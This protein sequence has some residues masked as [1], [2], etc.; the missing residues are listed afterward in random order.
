MLDIFFDENTYNRSNLSS[1]ASC[2]LYLPSHIPESPHK[3]IPATAGP[4]DF[5]GPSHVS[6]KGDIRKWIGETPPLAVVFCGKKKILT[7]G[8]E[9]RVRTG[10]ERSKQG[11][12][13]LLQRIGKG[14]KAFPYLFLLHACTFILL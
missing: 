8:D 3:T 10:L 5:D 11:N 4:G 1:P 2:F 6:P 13:F 12:I 7:A 14:G 9:E